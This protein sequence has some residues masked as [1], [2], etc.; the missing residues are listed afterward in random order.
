MAR[1][2]FLVAVDGCIEPRV[3]GPY[4]TKALR[5]KAAREIRK[6]QSED[7]ALFWADVQVGTLVVGCYSGGF[8]ME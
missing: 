3:E 8:F 5:E 1:R 6:E 2:F 7:D 4:R